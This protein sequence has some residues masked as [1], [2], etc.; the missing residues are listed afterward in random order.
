[1]PAKSVSEA[2]T[3]AGGVTRKQ[4]VVVIHGIGEQIPLQTLR[5]FVETVYQR[6]T[7]LN[8]GFG[9]ERTLETA[10]A[11]VPL[12]QTWIVPDDATGTAELRR[13]STPRD[14]NGLRTDFFE[15]Y[16][17]D[18]MDGTPIEEVLGW[19]RGLLLRSPFALPRDIRVWLA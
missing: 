13:I 16:W 14:Q 4:A 17:A 8:A 11:E 1:M 2:G 6:D 19:I 9:R 5:S 7:S 18:I 12:N 3:A 10:R 15:F